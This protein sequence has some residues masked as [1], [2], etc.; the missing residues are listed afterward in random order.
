MSYPALLQQ[1]RLRLSSSRTLLLQMPEHSRRYIL[2]D[3]SRNHSVIVVV[4]RQSLKPMA[5]ARHSGSGWRSVA[6][7]WAGLLPPVLSPPPPPPPL[8]LASV[9]LPGGRRRVGRRRCVGYRGTGGRHRRCGHEIFA[10]ADDVPP[11]RGE[12]VRRCPQEQD[13]GRHR[14]RVESRTRPA[15]QILCRSHEKE[16]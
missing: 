14:R 6:D 7:T 8:Q 3:S 4:A 10:T 12:T 5:T 2:R 13:V 9:L 15:R 1:R 16:G 11:C